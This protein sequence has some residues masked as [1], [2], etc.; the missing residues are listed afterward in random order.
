M[1]YLISINFV[2]ILN[3]QLDQCVKIIPKEVKKFRDEFQMH[4]QID[5]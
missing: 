1:L 2:Q 5:M 3:F 4:H